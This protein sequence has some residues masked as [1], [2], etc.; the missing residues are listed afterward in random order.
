MLN[1][2]ALNL[3]IEYCEFT[4]LYS[5]NYPQSSRKV[6]FLFMDAKDILYYANQLQ[7]LK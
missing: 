1:N 5:A 4:I 2:S 6:E 3:L 7:T